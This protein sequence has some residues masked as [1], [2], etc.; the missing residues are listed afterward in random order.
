MGAERLRS[1]VLSEVVSTD[2]PGRALTQSR[3]RP[4][5]RPCT[6]ASSDDRLQQSWAAGVRSGDNPFVSGIPAPV[7]RCVTGVSE[8][9][10]RGRFGLPRHLCR[11]HCVTEN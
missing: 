8:R 11:F 4:S 7:T 9:P 1:P 2:G 10:G 6:R 3:W 5:G